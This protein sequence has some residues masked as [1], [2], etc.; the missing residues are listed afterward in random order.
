MGIVFGILVS[1][2]QLLVLVGIVVFIVK[3]VAGR[4]GEQ[5]ATDSAPVTLKRLFLFGSLYASLHAAAWG[6][7]GLVAL[8]A[9]G[10][11]GRGERAAVPLAMTIVAVPI[12]FFLGR[13]ALRAVSDQQER[14]VAFAIYMNAALVTAFAVA[15]VTSIMTGSWLVGERGFPEMAL[16]SLLVW[17]PIWI[18]HWRLWRRYRRDVANL[19]VYVGATAGLGTMAGFGGAL[20]VEIFSRLLDS[21]TALE[22]GRGTDPDLSTWIVG[23]AVG[24]AVF[25][26]HWILTGTREERDTLWH[27]YVVL[28]GVL[29]GLITLVAGAGVT[30]FAVLQWWFGDPGTN[31]AVRHFEDFIPA[32]AAVIVGAAV[33]F[34]HRRV[35]GPVAGPRTE[36]QRVYDYVVAAVGLVTAVVGVVILVIGFQEAVFPPEDSMTSEVDILLGALTTLA[37]GAPLWAQSWRRINRFLRAHETA[38]LISPTRRSYLFGIIGIGGVVAAVSLIV[39]LVT[40]FNSV[41]GDG[42]GELRNNIQVPV[43]MIVTVGA[44][45]VYHLLLQRKEQ[46]H[47]PVAPQRP[48]QV[49]LV[50]GSETLAGEVRA[51]TGAGVTVL[52]RLDANGEVGDAGSVAAAVAAS[53]FEDLLV[54]LGPEGAVQVIPYRR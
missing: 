44:V 11:D 13:W 47:L 32:L 26:W 5:A 48:K 39:L 15:M 16:A 54:V 20:L 43:A 22:V 24:A 45:A 34:Y 46:K 52:H 31:S 8:L 7:A 10:V 4:R 35:L 38:E 37:V 50:T 42:N 14:G 29:G 53:E 40:I 23:F 49:V 25:A 51:L 41:L 12:L 1:F 28:I 18:G 9:E 21:G 36:V 27:A 19:H 6:V 2:V 17:T 33:W 3:A 30:L